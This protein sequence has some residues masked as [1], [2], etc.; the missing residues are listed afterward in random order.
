MLIFAL[1][2]FTFCD[3]VTILKLMAL[4]SN[5]RN[6]RPFQGGVSIFFFFN[7]LDWRPQ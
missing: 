5:H 3:G 1:F 6:L 2:C 4:C 7:P